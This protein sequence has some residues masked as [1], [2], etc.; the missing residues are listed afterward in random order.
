MHRNDTRHVA[1][2]PA[3]AR[4]ALAAAVGDALAALG[5]DGAE[6]AEAV[7]D[8]MGSRVCDLAELVDLEAV[9]F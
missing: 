9:E 2:L 7:G 1:A 8:A 5:L 6:R 4:L 3:A